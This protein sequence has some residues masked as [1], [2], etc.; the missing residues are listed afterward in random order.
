MQ[1]E[2]SC[3]T[4]ESTV[5]ALVFNQNHSAF[6]NQQVRQGFLRAI[7]RSALETF[8]AE[9]PSGKPARL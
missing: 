2:M 8:F 1:A 3:Q 7:D 5:W 6:S 4:A 9:Q